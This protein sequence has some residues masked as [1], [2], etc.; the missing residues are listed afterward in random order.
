MIKKLIVLCLCFLILLVFC[1]CSNN[2]CSCNCSC[3]EDSS[4]AST[5]ER[6]YT[7]SSMI[8]LSEDTNEDD[9]I[10]TSSD[11]FIDENLISDLQN[12]LDSESIHRRVKQEYPNTEY[13]FSLEHISET[14]MIR[15]NVLSA[16]EEDV[17]AICDEITKNFCEVARESLPD[18][19]VQVVHFASV[20][21]PES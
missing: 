19:S 13:R 15:I 18:I 6:T 20:A 8:Y 17:L 14:N 3:A 10:F 7:A 11:L 2:V 5:D 9:D 21:S 12:L 1:A 4:N 16:S